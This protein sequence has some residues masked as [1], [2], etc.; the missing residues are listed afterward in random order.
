MVAKMYVSKLN[1]GL[2]DPGSTFYPMLRITRSR[3]SSYPILPHAEYSK[4][5]RSNQQCDRLKALL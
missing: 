4:D 1:P 5:R 2:L 3:K